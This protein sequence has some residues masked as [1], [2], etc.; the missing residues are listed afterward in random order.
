MV[1][2]VNTP[3]F[4]GM[5]LLQVQAAGRAQLRHRRRSKGAPS[6]PLLHIPVAR[7]PPSLG[8]DC[9][10][11]VPPRVKATVWSK[12][13]C[14]KNQSFSSS[15]RATYHSSRGSRDFAAGPKRSPRPNAKLC[16]TI[17][18][19]VMGIVIIRSTTGLVLRMI[20][21]TMRNI[22]VG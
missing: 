17:I 7:R 16:D 20:L 3:F 22:V 8:V 21:I 14:P 18:G 10:Q 13:P 6:N 5:P 9:Y 2:P 19:V 11:G 12:K 15:S 1:S 4:R